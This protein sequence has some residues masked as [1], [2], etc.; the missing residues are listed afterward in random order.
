VNFSFFL[1]LNATIQ[2]SFSEKNAQETHF[3]K[4]RENLKKEKKQELD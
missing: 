4:G 2:Y 3:A 1:C